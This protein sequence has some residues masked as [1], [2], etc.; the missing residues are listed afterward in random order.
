[1]NSL[2]ASKCI[3]GGGAALGYAHI[4]AL[5]A[6]ENKYEVK[7]IL[8]TSMGAIIGA[9]Y[10]CQY[11]ADEICQIAKEKQFNKFIRLNLNIFREGILNTRKMYDFFSQITHHKRIEESS[12][13]YAS[14]AFDL[15]QKRTVIINQGKFADAMIASSNL[16][17]LNQAYPYQGALLVDG[18]VCYPFPLEFQNIFPDQLTSIAINVLPPIQIKPV[19]LSNNI[20]AD[21]TNHQN[22]LIYN[23]MLVNLYNQ[24]NLALDSLQHIKPD[25]YVNCFSEHLKAWDFHKVDEF[26][27]LGF[28][29][30]NQ[31]IQLTTEKHDSLLDE[32]RDNT[33]MLIKKIQ[34]DFSFKKL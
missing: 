32:I 10:A 4:G 6:L 25:I 30:T 17:F 33:R 28:H 26:F 9:L 20:P 16:P 29:Q 21:E 8:G 34:K 15:L 18:G 27:H 14:V 3:L 2:I 19:F 24:A 7:A 12:V 22:N 23:S 11:S 1:M 31:I 5:K 13:A